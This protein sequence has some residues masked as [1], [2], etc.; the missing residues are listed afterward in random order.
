MADPS[1]SDANTSPLAALSAWQGL[2]EAQ[3]EALRQLARRSSSAAVETSERNAAGAALAWFD[4]TVAVHH[5]VED[6][7][8]IPELLESMAGSDP[9]CLRELAAAATAGHRLV[10]GFWQRMRPAC[11]GL[12]HGTPALLDANVATA[13]I[14]TCRA[15]FEC[16]DRELV[17]IAGRLLDDAALARLQARLETLE[18]AARASTD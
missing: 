10:E 2:G 13:L 18:R 11:V 14:D 1:A 3:F 4:R 7:A 8:L 6:E 9:V 5:R 12:S 17:A 15:T 16:A